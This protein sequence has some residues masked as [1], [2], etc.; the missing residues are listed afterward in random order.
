MVGLAILDNHCSSGLLW[1]GRV[2]VC[3]GGMRRKWGLDEAVGWSWTG[4]GRGYERE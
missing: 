2:M 3:G 1:V 4:G